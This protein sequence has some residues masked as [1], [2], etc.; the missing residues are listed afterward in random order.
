MLT[1]RG[2]ILTDTQPTTAPGSD[3]AYIHNM[4]DE[5]AEVLAEWSEVRDQIRPD[6]TLAKPRKKIDLISEE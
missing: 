6:G 4:P 1:E 2:I 3:F 5:V